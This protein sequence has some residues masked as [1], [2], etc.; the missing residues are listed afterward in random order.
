MTRQYSALASQPRSAPTKAVLQ[1]EIAQQVIEQQVVSI[2][3]LK[4]VHP[5]LIVQVLACAAC[6][7]SQVAQ[8][9]QYR[10]YELRAMEYQILQ[11]L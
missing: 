10:R 9:R 3:F 8:V 1:T 5:P 2:K 6:F 11:A 7:P 4:I